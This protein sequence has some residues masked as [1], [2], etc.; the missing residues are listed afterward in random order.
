VGPAGFEMAF[1]T[2]AGD[3]VAAGA[4]FAAAAGVGVTLFAVDAAGF[5]ALLG[6]VRLNC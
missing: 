3:L 2:T 6:S 5:G 4:G 1:A